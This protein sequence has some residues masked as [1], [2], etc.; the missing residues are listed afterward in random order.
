MK[1]NFKS[2]LFYGQNLIPLSF[3]ALIEIK[4]LVWQFD[5]EK[6]KHLNFFF[7]YNFR[8]KKEPKRKMEKT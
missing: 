8:S 5:C 2:K 4:L 3:S 6:I 1:V 7:R